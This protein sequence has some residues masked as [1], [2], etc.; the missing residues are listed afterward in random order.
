[1]LE[2]IGRQ[3]KFVEMEITYSDVV[4]ESRTIIFVGIFVFRK[5]ERGFITLECH[6]D[7]LPCSP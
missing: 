7:P 4:M 2:L 3:I 5:S 1:M 6:I